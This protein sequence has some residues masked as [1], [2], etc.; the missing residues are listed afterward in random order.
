MKTIIAM[1]LLMFSV[2]VAASDLCDEITIDPLGRGYS[3][4]TP[5]QIITDLWT[6]YRSRWKECVQGADLLDAIEAPDWVAIT[7]NER[8]RVLLILGLGCM[9]PQKNVRT[10][11]IG[12]FGSGSQT[13]SNM[14]AAAQDAI[15]RGDELGLG[16]VRVADI[17]RCQQ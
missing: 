6:A 4:M 13:I 11:L 10:L 1:L 17:E 3:G 5:D 8:D 16:K 2:S 12:I 9:D 15:T 7:D 14:A